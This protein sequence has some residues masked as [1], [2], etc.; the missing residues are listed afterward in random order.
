MMITV[1]G[2]SNET[3][4]YLEEKT[5]GNVFLLLMSGMKYLDLELCNNSICNIWLFKNKETKQNW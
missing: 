1:A 5:W 4:P 2:E 3:H